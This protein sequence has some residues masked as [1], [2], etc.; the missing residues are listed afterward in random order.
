MEDAPIAPPPP[1]SQ[2]REPGV[3][4][5]LYWGRTPPKQQFS[6]LFYTWK[7]RKKGLTTQ[8]APTDPALGL[9]QPHAAIRWGGGGGAR[10]GPS[11]IPSHPIPPPRTWLGSATAPA[12]SS[13]LRPC[14]A[15]LLVPA[16]MGPWL[17]T[18]EAPDLGSPQPQAELVR[19]AWPCVFPPNFLSSATDYHHTSAPCSPQELPSPGQ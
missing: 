16:G 13:L 4:N 8:A 6:R 7:G 5:T 14:P 10:T 1:H 12:T 19:T 18:G 11:L 9:S 15:Q 2:H 3:Q 17:S